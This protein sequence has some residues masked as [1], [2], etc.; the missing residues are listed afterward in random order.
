MMAMKEQFQIDM[1]WGWTDGPEDKVLAGKQ[2]G[3]RKTNK[4]TNKQKK[5]PEFGS[6]APT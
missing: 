5:N 6:L 1:I 4:Q 3:K 2:K